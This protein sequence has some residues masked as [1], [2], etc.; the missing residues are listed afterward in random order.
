MYWYGEAFFMTTPWKPEGSASFSMDVILTKH[1]RLVEEQ[2]VDQLTADR[3]QTTIKHN[4]CLSGV[5]SRGNSV[6][7]SLLLCSLALLED[8][9]KPN[10]ASSRCRI[11]VKFQWKWL[12]SRLGCVHCICKQ[13][14][15]FPRAPA[16][17]SRMRRYSGLNSRITARSQVR[18]PAWSLCVITFSLV[19]Q[20][21]KIIL[22]SVKT[23]LSSETKPIRMTYTAHETNRSFLF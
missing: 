12:F 13:A 23:K 3:K 9:P 16:G 5:P 17:P 21:K 8:H 14:Q 10:E 18:F 6:K 7:D 19:S 4:M 1:Q 11:Y 15:G 20:T 2:Q 22:Q